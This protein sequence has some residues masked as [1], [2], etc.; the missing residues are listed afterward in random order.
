MGSQ[1]VE[2]CV[3]SA[4]SSLYPPFEVT[5]PPLLSQVFSVLEG[6]Y[7]H[8]SLRYL[9]DFFVPAKHLLQRLQQEACSQYIGFLFLH[10]GW[11][12]CLHEKVVVHL[13]TLDWK[14]L[15]PGDFYLQVVPFSA[16][17][18]RLAV[19]CLST[20]GRTVQEI[21][22]PESDHSHIFTPEW[23]NGL[24]KER[25]GARLERC[26]LIT[27]T[28]LIR[29]TWEEIVYPQFIHK[30]G[31]I[32]GSLVTS[33][34]P[35][36][37]KVPAGQNEEFDHHNS[38]IPTQPTE[39]K[40]LHNDS[41]L[42]NEL[43]GEYVELLEIDVKECYLNPGE[44]DSKR[45]YLEVHGISKTKT[46]PLCKSQNKG[47]SKRHRAWLH[48]KTGGTVKPLLPC[49]MTQVESPESSEQFLNMGDHEIKELGPE[50][51]TDLRGLVIEPEV[52]HDLIHVSST[53]FDHFSSGSDGEGFSPLPWTDSP[54]LQIESRHVESGAQN[55]SSQENIFRKS[56][57]N[58]TNQ[59]AAKDMSNKDI[60]LL[61]L[62]MHPSSQK[63]NCAIVE[64]QNLTNLPDT[65]NDSSKVE[66]SESVGSSVQITQFSQDKASMKEEMALSLCNDA[67]QNQQ[68]VL[69]SVKPLGKKKNKQGDKTPA[70]EKTLDIKNNCNL[71]L[72]RNN[73]GNS[74][75]VAQGS[76]EHPVRT[77]TKL[78]S[79][80]SLVPTTEETKSKSECNNNSN[81]IC[82]MDH[83]NSDLKKNPKG[84][85]LGSNNGEPSPAV[86]EGGKVPVAKVNVTRNPASK[87]N[88]RKK[89][90]KSG[91]GK[92]KATE[93]AG[94]GNKALQNAKDRPAT[95]SKEKQ[96][97]QTQ[98]PDIKAGEN[99]T[100]SDL[101]AFAT[102]EPNISEHC[103]PGDNGEH[104]PPLPECDSQPQV[105]SSADDAGDLQQDS[106]NQDVTPSENC[107]MTLRSNNEP[108]PPTG[109]HHTHSLDGEEEQPKVE[110]IADDSCSTPHL[111]RD[112]N[113]ELLLSGLLTLPGT[114]DKEG[115]NLVLIEMK[116]PSWQYPAEE[117]ARALACFHSLTRVSSKESDLTI[118]LDSRRALF[119]M[120]IL[121]PLQAFQEK[122][123]SAI[124][125]V[126][127]VLDHDS[128]ISVE[129][130]S[131][132][133]LV[134]VKGLSAL[135]AHVDSTQL[136]IS[137]GGASV[138][139]HSDWISF[140]LR[141]EEFSLSCQRA[142]SLLGEALDFLEKHQLPDSTK[143]VA[144]CV[145]D[146]QKLMKTVLVDE[147]ITCLQ[148]EG[149]AKL[150]RLRR[151]ADHSSMSQTCRDS[152][153][154][155]SDLYN[156]VDDALHQLVMLSN[157]RLRDLETIGR[158]GALES[159]L[160]KVVH[161]A[162]EVGMTSLESY[163]DLGDS[164]ELL[165]QKQKEFIEFSRTAGE[166]CCDGFEA[167][168]KIE[169]WDYFPSPGLQVIQ[170][171]VPE[172][173][174]KLQEF[175]N[176]VGKCQSTMEK[177]I[178][179]YE[180]FSE[181][182][183]WSLEVMRHLSQ[184]SAEDCMSSAHC[185]EALVRLQRCCRD[186]PEISEAR[187]AEAQSIAKE[188]GNTTSNKTIMDHWTFA[189]TKYTETC[190]VLHQRLEMAQKTQRAKLGGVPSRSMT[191]LCLEAQQSVLHSWGSLASLHQDPFFPNHTSTLRADDVPND[192][193]SLG[194]NTTSST[195][196]PW[197][198]NAVL[199][200]SSSRWYLQGFLKDHTKQS[201]CLENISAPC[202]PNRKRNPSFDFQALL[203]S[204][205]ASK[206]SGKAEDS[207]SSPLLW[208]GRKSAQLGP[209]AGQT[210]VHIKGL[211]VSSREVVDQTCSPRQ[212]VLLART[213]V[214]IMNAPWGCTPKQERKNTSSKTQRLASVLASSELEYVSALHHVEECY[215]PETERRDLPQELRGKR[216]VIF[217]NW[218]K[219][220]AFHAHFLLPI[221]ED[222]VSQPLSLGDCFLKFRQ[223]F[224]LYSLYIK[225]KPKCDVLLS[226][227]GNSF[228]KRR[229]LELK[230][231][232]DLSQYLQAPLLRLQQ[233]CDILNELTKECCPE[234]DQQSLQSLQNAVAMLRFVIQHGEDLQASDRITACDVSLTEQG[235]LLRQNEFTVLGGRK[236]VIRQMFLFEDLL[237]FTKQKTLHGGQTAYIYK[238]SVK[239]ADIGLT[240][241]IGDSGTRFEIWVRHSKSKEAYIL[242]ARSPDVKQM[243][244]QD[245]ARLLWSQA[246]RNKELRLQESLSMGMCSKPFLDIKSSS[247]NICDRNIDYF[248]NG[249]GSR[250]RA[251][252]AVSS[253]SSD[254]SFRSPSPLPSP[255]LSPGLGP[256]DLHFGHGTHFHQSRFYPESIKEEDDAFST[257]NLLDSSGS[258]SCGSGQQSQQ[259]LKS[260]NLDVAG[261]F[262]HNSSSSSSSQYKMQKSDQHVERQSTVV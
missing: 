165:R 151:E 183:N 28:G 254:S 235:E 256:L 241:N 64:G 210:G 37:L 117:V 100:A 226:S 240:E 153:S 176:A 107:E 97:V 232:L 85:T 247:S 242:Q 98:D 7:H 44:A 38:E 201:T 190:S 131:L 93:Q 194:I 200:P 57:D 167:L 32:V 61:N 253:F 198:G 8:D 11:P 68:P 66:L 245:L 189:K 144:S 205:R 170:E 43:E 257:G 53:E 212:H 154:T 80:Q 94:R 1:A 225:N 25:T 229:Q 96:S 224:K 30:P 105:V 36:L 86:A 82:P 50:V 192:N 115:H 128:T 27:D 251:S 150:A 262:N 223:Q 63:T 55:Q 139:C 62:S 137:L 166:H 125:R 95:P 88:R 158:L 69:N 118:L 246:M 186:L 237:L 71:L 122:S 172:Y 126:L 239:T 51:M 218:E 120:D 213:G 45:R 133:Q 141:L 6:T 113:P 130:I 152:L 244:T 214:P 199:K 188:I 121:S 149:G 110:Q 157:Q 49:S 219:L 119:S 162:S 59:K 19:K 180:F 135:Q 52:V 228:F 33:T 39:G 114:H 258:S 17:T 108:D 16:R 211:E 67:E 209:K 164:L 41:N 76:S 46:V 230:D 29:A 24:N 13:S 208:L 81:L 56:D 142:L 197:L 238:H 90:G 159:K 104:L 109:E 160:E 169:C 163:K 60:P 215:L 15:Q 5:A 78:P 3:Q 179:L 187:F 87:G 116:N 217:A 9:V 40:H 138:H 202:K 204:R 243:W 124:Y 89:K 252:V 21:L 129:N 148:M 10:E 4:L 132:L 191:N 261:L 48:P 106:S 20:G 255:L 171:K 184:V 259:D 35:T 216:G 181:A 58:G 147:R 140:Q 79:Q 12:L 203:G 34:D 99:D 177:T 47:K 65:V 127:L 185:S 112:L 220:T 168:R 196:F 156:R 102:N 178:Q 70:T 123:P 101:P 146:H 74:T 26:L 72:D 14:N 231:P 136:P 145:D 249:R 103:Q 222:A 182:Y 31:S 221:I 91:R 84:K 83:K 143:T 250:S 111:L 234:R 173:R 134:V 260:M 23:L 2:D 75:T 233:Y 54:T 161:W 175:S 174:Q 206:D 22:V 227:Q 236:K 42:K 92:S 155:T 207:V 193:N 73:S 18:P 248:L 195:S 77:E